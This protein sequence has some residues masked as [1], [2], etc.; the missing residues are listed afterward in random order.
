MPHTKKLVF[1][2]SRQTISTTRNV[3]IAQYLFLILA[4][5]GVMLRQASLFV[6]APSRRFSPLFFRRRVTEEF[7]MSSHNPVAER[8]HIVG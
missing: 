4:Q 8:I 3:K 7:E 1:L 2:V 6:S 5:F